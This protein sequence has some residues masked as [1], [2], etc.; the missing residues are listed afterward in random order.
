MAVKKCAGF[1]AVS[2]NWTHGLNYHCSSYN[3]ATTT[4]LHWILYTYC[5][6]GTKHF[7]HRSAQPPS[8]CHP[9]SIWCQPVSTK[10]LCGFFHS[11]CFNI[12]PELKLKTC[13]MLWGEMEISATYVH[14]AIL[15]HQLCVFQV[16]HITI[17]WGDMPH[18]DLP[19]VSHVRHICPSLTNYL[20]WNL[21]L[22]YVWYVVM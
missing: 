12:L 17:S 11:K 8:M 7:S 18:A 4:N 19:N 5:K 16:Y 15:N 22:P 10:M 2:K 6:G 13:L 14:V 9:S 1:G 21:A 3:W 20:I